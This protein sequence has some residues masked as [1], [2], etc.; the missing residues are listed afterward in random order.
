MNFKEQY[1]SITNIQPTD[2]NAE[3]LSFLE[4]KTKEEFISECEHPVWLWDMIKDKTEIIELLSEHS[5]DL[6]VDK[7]YKRKHPFIW[8]KKEREQELLKLKDS[9]EYNF[10]TFFNSLYPNKALPILKQYLNDKS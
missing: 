4:G 1:I 7:S 5:K 9:K 10:L 8:T 2:S 6:V 3:L